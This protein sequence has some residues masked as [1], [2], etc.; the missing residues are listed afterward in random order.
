MKVNTH[1]PIIYLIFFS[2][3]LKDPILR[4][5]H[6]PGPG[7]ENPRPQAT[8][9]T[10]RGPRVHFSSNV[11]QR[12][13]QR[14][15]VIRHCRGVYSFLS[16]TFRRIWSLPDYK[17]PRKQNYGITAR[18]NKNNPCSFSFFFS[19]SACKQKHELYKKYSF[20][21]HCEYCFFLLSLYPC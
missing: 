9:T 15:L 5:Q 13:K 16:Y 17:S 1:T 3:F 18:M 20:L 7:I 11:R 21:L 10:R 6:I 14:A 4:D 12:V 19:F 8:I 2:S